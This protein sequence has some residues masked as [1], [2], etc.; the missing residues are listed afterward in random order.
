ME[1]PANLFGFPKGTYAA[2]FVSTSSQADVTAAVKKA[3]D[4]AGWLRAAGTQIPIGDQNGDLVGELDGSHGLQ[5]IVLGPDVMATPDLATLGGL[6]PKGSTLV[7][8]VVS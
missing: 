1:D 7:L 5:I 2:T 6:L 4:D 3:F 8:Y